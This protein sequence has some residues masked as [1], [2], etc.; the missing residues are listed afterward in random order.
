MSNQLRWPKIILGTI[1]SVVLFA[2]NTLAATLSS[3][4]SPIKSSPATNLAQNSQAIQQFQ[5]GI[6]LFKKGDLV[7]AETAF[8]K[9]IQIDSNFAAAYANLGSVLVNQE[10]LTEAVP[11][12]ESA[13][14][15]KPDEP[16]LYYQLGLTLYLA[17][18]PQEAKVPLTKARDLL[19]KQ[20]KNT[21]ASQIDKALE[22]I[23]SK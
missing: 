3:S 11:Q 1:T 15:L 8:R 6:E 22:R 10:K 23:N 4:K 12:F 2:N 17:G 19:K 9:A 13:I 5:Q 7:A 20:G 21:E 16:Q 18:R 14:R